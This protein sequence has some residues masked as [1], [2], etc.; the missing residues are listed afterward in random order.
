MDDQGAAVATCE[1]EVRGRVDEAWF[2][3]LGG[4]T[5]R[6]EPEPGGLGMSILTG[7]LDQAALRG[8]LCHLW[9]L[10]LTVVSV[11]THETHQTQEPAR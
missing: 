9:D 1:I 3:W 6:F 8:L 2:D 11:A 10:N 7:S 4:V 5:M